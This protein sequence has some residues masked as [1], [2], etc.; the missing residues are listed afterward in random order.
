MLLD[1]DISGSISNTISYKGWRLGVLMN[2][3]M[4]NKVRLF[5]LFDQGDNSGTSPDH[6]Y[7]E[8]NL[9]RD[10]LRRWKKPG[11]ERYTNIPSIMS[12]N[13]INYY[14]YSAHWSSG[15]NYTGV[16]IAENSWDMYDYS[17]LRTVSGDYLRLAN[18]SLTY[19]VPSSL[20]SKYRLQRLAFTIS[21]TNLY[22]WCSKALK[23]QTPTQSGF[24]TVQLS[25]TP[26]YTFG[27]NIQF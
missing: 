24:S 23:G 19:E 1:P 14:K 2:Y 25:D 3:S 16:K 12:Q 15:S 18:V 10:I 11:D 22:T 13:A 9:S 5:R 8:F 27:V 17:D 7:P 20:L 26:Y 21:G 6:I 4:G